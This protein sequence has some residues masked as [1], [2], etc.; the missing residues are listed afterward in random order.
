[1]VFKAV[2]IKMKI[3]FYVTGYWINY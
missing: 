2:V 1:M 3:D